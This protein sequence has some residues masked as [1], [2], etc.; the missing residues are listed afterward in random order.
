MSDIPK[1]VFST[2]QCFK[3]VLVAICIN[4]YI[5]INLQA[6]CDDA[7]PNA[8]DFCCLEASSRMGGIE[9]LGKMRHSF[10]R[11]MAFDKSIS[12]S[13][14]KIQSKNLKRKFY[15]NVNPELFLKYE[16]IVFMPAGCAC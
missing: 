15:K 10:V 16:S 1:N 4:L 2:S 14:N 3:K 8:D 12:E 6:V 5:P 11:K 13:S 9:N 7:A